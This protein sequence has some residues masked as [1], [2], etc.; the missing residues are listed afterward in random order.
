MLSDEIASDGITS[1]GMTSNEIIPT[2]RVS[3]EMNLNGI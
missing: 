1:A 3:D 2:G